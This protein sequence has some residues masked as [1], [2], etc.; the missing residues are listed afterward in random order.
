MAFS[1]KDERFIEVV[2]A[3]A[4]FLEG[5]GEI[6]REEALNKISKWYH[7]DELVRNLTFNMVDGYLTDRFGEYW[8]DSRCPWKPME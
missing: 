5:G 7:P 1:E 4:V 6:T 3:F 8:L 2:R